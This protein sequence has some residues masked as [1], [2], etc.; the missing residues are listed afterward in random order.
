VA[1]SIRISK[2]SEDEAF[3]RYGFGFDGGGHRGTL[4]LT[5]TTGEITLVEAAS[6]DDWG[7]CFRRA[8]SRLRRHWS[9]GVLPRLTEWAP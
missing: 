4:A 8:A 5:K 6:G 9:E 2:I 1:F 3:A 7:H